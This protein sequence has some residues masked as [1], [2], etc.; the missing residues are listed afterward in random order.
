M[1]KFVLGFV[2]GILIL[3]AGFLLL[4][5]LGVFPALANARFPA[6][7]SRKRHTTFR[8][9]PSATS[10]HNSGWLDSSSIPMS[11][12]ASCVHL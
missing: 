7:G 6:S 4:A 2:V 5:W 10:E 3:P 1:R 12:V 9:T 11:F 8:V